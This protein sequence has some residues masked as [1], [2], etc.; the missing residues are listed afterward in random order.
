MFTSKRKYFRFAFASLVLGLALLNAAS[1]AAGQRRRG[2]TTTRP[3]VT[4][5]EV[6][7]VPQVVQARPVAVAA[8]A[9][10]LPELVRR[11]KPSVVAI[12]VFDKDGQ[13]IGLGSAFFI[14]PGRIVTNYHVI[15]GGNMGEI[16]TNE[17]FAYSVPRILSADPNTDLAIL[18]V[19]LPT[20]VQIRALP[21]ARSGAEEGESIVVIGTPMGL[22]GTVSQGIISRVRRYTNEPQ[23]IQITAPI[24]HG[25]SGSPV[26]NMRGEV[27][28]IAVGGKS[29][30]Q[31]LNFAVP[32]AALGTLSEQAERWSRVMR[33]YEDG[34]RLNRGGNYERALEKF[35]EAVKMSPNYVAAWLGAGHTYLALN[36]PA[37]ALISFSE[38]TRIDPNNAE[39][40]YG[41]GSA[42]AKQGRYADAISSFRRVL[43]IHPN[44]VEV[45]VEVGNAYFSLNDTRSAIDSYKQAL[46]I[47]PNYALAHYNLGLAYLARGDRK[48]ARKQ[49]NKL[50]ELG[51][52]QLASDL[53]QRIPR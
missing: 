32:S 3:R 20:G 51:A 22:Q 14:A 33:L 10:S 24:S 6:R 31:N 23:L 29:E 19:E 43:L 35:T 5:P 25:S 38:V 21:I 30:G 42:Y 12:R 27:I 28:G 40:Y 41:I 17:G 37:G 46:R 53:W 9:V 4:Q 45:Y 18:E 34:M 7:R 8:P 16:Y 52:T 15:E 47:R 39:A 26:I 36:D 13:A 49:G 48:A 1:P 50:Q 2:K 11:I 44:N